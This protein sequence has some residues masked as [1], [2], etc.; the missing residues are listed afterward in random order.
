MPPFRATYR[1]EKEETPH[2]ITALFRKHLLTA[3]LKTEGVQ[4]I[5]WSRQECRD[6]HLHEHVI[7]MPFQAKW[8]TAS[9]LRRKEALK[10]A[11][12]Q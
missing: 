5:R 12:M 8:L 6:F 11:G 10:A 7:E 9:L 2:S 4:G 3:A 1:E